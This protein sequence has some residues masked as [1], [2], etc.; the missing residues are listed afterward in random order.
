MLHDC[1]VPWTGSTE[2]YDV[3][4]REYLVVDIGRECILHKCMYVS[5]IIQLC[6]HMYNVH[7]YMRIYHVYVYIICT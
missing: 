5:S 4:V 6:I 1:V 2:V 3:P 7:T